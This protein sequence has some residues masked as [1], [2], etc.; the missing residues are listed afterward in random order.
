MP[1]LQE[2]VSAAVGEFITDP[3]ARGYGQTLSDVSFNAGLLSEQ[4][5]TDVPR[6]LVSGQ[7][8]RD[9]V[10]WIEYVAA[11]TR[12]VAGSDPDEYVISDPQH[13]FME[14]LFHSNGVDLRA[15]SYTAMLV[16]IFPAG[17]SNRPALNAL[18]SVVGSRWRALFGSEPRNLA[19]VNQVS[20]LA[21]EQI[22]GP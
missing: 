13:E 21:L 12:L 20:R 18:R 5:F 15:G 17:S 6:G 14:Q 11:R 7:Q 2:R 8:I 22:V 16:A 10:D 9:A 1:S 4:V 19:I 3:K